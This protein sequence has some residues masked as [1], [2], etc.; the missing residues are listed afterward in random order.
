M[1]SLIQKSGFT[2]VQIEPIRW[3]HGLPEAEYLHVNCIDEQYGIC[4][5]L[6]YKLLD[7]SGNI[8]GELKG[9]NPVIKDNKYRD[10]DGN[11]LLFPFLFVASFLNL[12]VK[13]DEQ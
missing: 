1:N 3:Q 9:E 8:V 12:K 2:V 7:K 13:E 11:D 5:K 10:W 6:N 4:A